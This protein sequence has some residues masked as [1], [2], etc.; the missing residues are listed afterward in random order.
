MA[1]SGV[2][3]YGLY[4]KETIRKDELICYYSGYVYGKSAMLGNRSDYVLDLGG[5]WY[6][7][8]GGRY[9]AAGRYINDAKGHKGV[10]NN[11]RFSGY[12]L[13]DTELGWHIGVYATRHIPAYREIF[14]SYGTAYWSK[15]KCIYGTFQRS[16]VLEC[17]DKCTEE[18]LQLLDK[19]IGIED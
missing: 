4:S 6:L 11:C 7:D 19:D 9:N 17:N 15:R 13:F 8:G 3:G 18:Q 12:L 16:G 5:G 2:A 10:R 14:C 1:K